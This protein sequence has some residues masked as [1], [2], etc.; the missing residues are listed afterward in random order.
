L[1]LS[2][3]TFGFLVLHV[4]LYHMCRTWYLLLGIE[5]VWGLALPYVLSSTPVFSCRM[6]FGLYQDHTLH[7]DPMICG[8]SIFSS[9]IA[10]GCWF[11][12]NGLRQTSNSNIWKHAEGH[13]SKY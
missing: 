6:G 5:L 1:C 9:I 12:F 10:L 11:D 4:L 3:P 13:V 2:N 7:R 8:L